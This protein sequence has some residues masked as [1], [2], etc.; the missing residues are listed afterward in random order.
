MQIYVFQLLNGIGIGMIYFL[1]SVGLSIIFG[2]LNFVNFA[3]GAFFLA[4]AYLCFEIASRT[5][6]F[7]TALA[8]APLGV[9][10]LGWLLNKLLLARV[11]NLSHS[12][13]ILV[14][15]GIMLVLQE[16]V[17]IIWGS[18]G[19]NV[20]VP[21]L[22]NGV[23]ILES[24][25]YPKY[26]LFVI[27]FS[28]AIALLLYI[29]LERTRFGALIR[30]ASEDGTMVSLLGTDVGRVVSLTFALGGLLAGLGGVVA[31][32]LRGVDP[33]MGLDALAIAF[34]VVIVGGLGSFTGALLGGLTIGIVQSMMSSIWPEGARLMIYCFVALV[35]LVR[36]RGLLG[37]T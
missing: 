1:V 35:L 3:H 31:A 23:I 10:A 20:P 12:A 5:G 26:R 36:P 2:L 9:A 25:V 17:V 37:R 21:E 11:M 6:S 32:P 16:L 19:K 18:L 27:L 30:A 34:A 13:H 22:L 15:F 33:A 7:W 28:A 24:F 29:L 14:T 4:G 8:I